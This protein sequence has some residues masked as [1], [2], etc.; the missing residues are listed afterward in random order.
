VREL[1][2]TA[3]GGVSCRW[4]TH[5]GGGVLRISLVAASRWPATVEGFMLGADNSE[6]G[7]VKNTGGNSPT[8]T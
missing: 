2:A 1:P 6:F 4:E 3:E 5:C 8:G 7:G